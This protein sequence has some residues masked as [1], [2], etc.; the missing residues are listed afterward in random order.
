[1]SI[2]NLPLG[3][4]FAPYMLSQ[5]NQIV[6]DAT[7]PQ[8]KLDYHG[9]LELLSDQ[10][11]PGDPFALKLN[12]QA[13]HRKSVQVSFRQRFTEDFTGTNEGDVCDVTN[14]L[15]RREATVE[16]SSFRFIAMS[17]ED[18]T[19][20][21]YEDDA[22]KTVALGLPPTQLMNELYEDVLA[23]AN[24]LLDGVDTDLQTLAA[25][26]FGVNRVSGN[27]AAVSVNLNKA[28]TVNNLTDGITKILSDFQINSGRG[29]PIVW[30]S[31][32]MNNFMNQLPARSANQSGYNPAIEAQ[33]LKWYFDQKSQSVLGANQIGVM[34][35]NALQ[36]VEYLEFTGFKKGQFPGNSIF[37][38]LPLPMRISNGDLKKVWFDYQLRYS[39]C[40][41]T[42]TDQ[43]YGTPI[44]L[45][46]GW[47][48]ILSKH[49]GLF[50]IP[51]DAYRGTDVL[52]GNRGTYRYTITNN[53]DNC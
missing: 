47:T 27:N 19:I 7:T 53:C 49:S 38:V 50:T 14:I 31:G 37:G 3:Q 30:G 25:A 21:R 5:M 33:G 42:I 51:S 43:Y 28:G 22:S 11:S 41:K 44:T 12:N 34:E 8:Y 16:L 9:F 36:W 17:L 32:L 2:T 26:N 13:G 46:K 1:M 48:L 24:A 39:D 23:S 18:E 20:A 10:R 29:T 35:A 6:G 45:Q 52:S 40:A 4:G 15:P